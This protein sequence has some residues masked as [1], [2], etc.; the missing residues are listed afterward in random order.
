[1]RVDR[2]RAS[3]GSSGGRCGHPEAGA[4]EVELPVRVAK[5]LDDLF[6]AIVALAQTTS[7]N[8][9]GDLA[10]VYQN[11][12]DVLLPTA[13]VRPYLASSREQRRYRLLDR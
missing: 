7:T 11:T 9:L 4:L 1:M 5:R 10:C 8:P 2:S 13:V 3:R 6:L 12:T